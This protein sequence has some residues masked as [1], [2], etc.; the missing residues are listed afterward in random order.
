MTVLAE[1][2]GSVAQ[3]K[4][5]QQAV[6]AF[7]KAADGELIGRR[8]NE[9]IWLI[10]RLP[11]MVDISKNRSPLNQALNKSI[12]ESFQYRN[13]DLVQIT[14]EHPVNLQEQMETFPLRP[15]EI[16]FL[17]LDNP[18]QVYVCLSKP[19]MLA[20]QSAWLLVHPVKWAYV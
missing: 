11:Q 9:K 3:E 7:C 16:W 13:G 19:L 12:I 4:A 20:K 1:I 6:E 8:V 10:V 14:F 2:V 15:H 5:I 18:Y 17:A